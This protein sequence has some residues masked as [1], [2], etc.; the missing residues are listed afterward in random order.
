M[1]R[2][3][4]DVLSV[5]GLGSCVAVVLIVPKHGIVGLA[6]VVLPEA[7]MTGGREAPPAKFADTAVPALLVA[8]RRQRVKPN[9]VYAILVGG[10]TMFG[11]GEQSKLA[12]VGDRNVEAAHHYL[13]LHGIGV[14]SEDVGG[15]SGRSVQVTVNGLR[16]FVR[17]GAA[18]PFEML[19]SPTPLT[20]KVPSTE[21]DLQPEPFPDD[22]WTSESSPR[23]A[24]G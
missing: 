9:D 1:S 7:R 24:M 6:H 13:A 11:H 12:G 2:S 15:V 3:K 4:R 21:T 10:A 5:V 22:I 23:S 8:L 20:V 16:V 18:E 17:S 19:G 14:V